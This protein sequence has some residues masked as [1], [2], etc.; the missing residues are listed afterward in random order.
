LKSNA[1]TFG[2][3]G[4]AGRSRELEDAATRGALEGASEQ[5]EAM[6]SELGLVL[7]ALPAVWRK[8]SAGPF[9]P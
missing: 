3:H 6:G 1:A 9:P 5:V 7:E 8:L 4:L 2:A